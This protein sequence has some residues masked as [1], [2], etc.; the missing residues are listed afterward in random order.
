M[1]Y[2]ALTMMVATAVG[3]NAY[4]SDE[5]SEKAR[6]DYVS[7]ADWHS[8]NITAIGAKDLRFGPKLKDD[9]YLEYEY[10]GKKGPIQ[11]FGYIDM[12]RFF[13][14]GNNA[15]TGI[16]GKGSPIF[17]E[18]QPRLSLNDLV[19]KDLGVGIFKDWFAAVDWVYDLGTSKA[20]RQNTLFVGLGTD[21]N[22]YSKLGLSINFF[23]RKQYENY[24]A[25]NSNSWDGYRLQIKYRY[26]LGD[27]LGGKLNYSGFTNFDFKSKLGERTPTLRTN[28]ATVATNALVY[29]RGHLKLLGVAR[30][31]HNGGQWKDEASLGGST[32]SS[33]GWGYYLG[34]GYIF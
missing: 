24:G 10:F 21:I 27:L 32:I 29:T 14:I 17:M 5:V 6:S 15:S 16:W 3:A 34:V 2:I 9:I 4:A 30:Y 23:G 22:T 13:G 26:P 25:K 20:S 11:Y 19:G 28:S 33:K 1:K 8:H 18:H 12:P 31:F 7:T